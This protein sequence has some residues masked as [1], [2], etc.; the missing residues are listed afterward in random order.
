MFSPAVPTHQNSMS[1]SDLVLKCYLLFHPFLYIFIV[2]SNGLHHHI[3]IYVFT[4]IP[5][6]ILPAPF[7]LA[8]F[9]FQM[10]F[11]FYVFSPII[12]VLHRKGRCDTCGSESD[13]SHLTQWSLN[14][15]HFHTNVISFFLPSMELNKTPFC[16]YTTFSSSVHLLTTPNRLLNLDSHI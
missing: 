11:Y 5:S 13:L 10:V 3:F 14:C 9:S 7:P 15:I 6:P 16:I 8:P 4:H 12:Q 2:E 1:I